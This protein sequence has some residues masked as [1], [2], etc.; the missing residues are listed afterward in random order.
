MEKLPGSV[1]CPVTD[2]RR[3]RRWVRH[4]P[5]ALAFERALAHRRARRAMREVLASVTVGGT[6]P[7]EAILEGIVRAFTDHDVS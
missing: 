4:N 1:P 2:I 5:G 6:D 3:S 7:D